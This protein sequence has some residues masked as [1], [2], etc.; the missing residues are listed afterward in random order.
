MKKIILTLALSLSNCVFAL[1][2]DSCI[3][4]VDIS[5]E[6]AKNQLSSQGLLCELC[7]DLVYDKLN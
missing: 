1:P 2:V 7:S 6:N 5:I 3:A 4:H